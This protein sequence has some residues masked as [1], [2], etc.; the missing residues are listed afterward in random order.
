[1]EEPPEWVQASGSLTVLGFETDA[2]PDEA[3][4]GSMREHCAA[5]VPGFLRAVE[6]QDNSE[7]VYV[8]EFGGPERFMMEWVF[9]GHLDDAQIRAVWLAMVEACTAHRMRCHLS[10]RGMEFP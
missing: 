1:M 10:N 6:A 7:G 9:V 2:A 4:I 8:T 5:V 3:A